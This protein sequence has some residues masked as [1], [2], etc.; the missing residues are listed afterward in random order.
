MKIFT[1]DTWGIPAFIIFLV[2]WVG[3]CTLARPSDYYDD[4]TGYQLV[5]GVD[6]PYSWPLIS[7]LMC[8]L[9]AIT[10]ARA[11]YEIT[12]NYKTK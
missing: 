1:K 12:E 11:I 6:A 9:F 5:K 4:N 7:H 3:Y 10:L 8:I 2:S